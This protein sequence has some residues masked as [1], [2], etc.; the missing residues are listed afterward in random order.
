MSFLVAIAFKGF[1]RCVPV[2]YTHLDVYKRQ[3]YIQN[4]DMVANGSEGLGLNCPNCGAPIKSLGQ[5]FCEYCG[6]FPS[7]KIP[8]GFVIPALT[9]QTYVC[10]KKYIFFYLTKP[11][12]R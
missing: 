3:V 8:S 11:K 9:F 10:V 1:R 7:K 2:S 4:V 5:K 6:V 12:M